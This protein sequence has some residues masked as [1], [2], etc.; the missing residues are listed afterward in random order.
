MF[1]S[2]ETTLDKPQEN[3]IERL[4]QKTRI[5]VML[6]ARFFQKGEGN[7]FPPRFPLVLESKKQGM[8]K[9]V[10]GGDVRM[11]AIEQLYEEFQSS[12]ENQDTRLR[13]FTTG[14]T[15]EIDIPETGETLK[16]SRAKQAENKL[17]V[18]Y[19][20]PRDI[21][22]TLPSGGSTI[23]NAKA[24]AEWLENNKEEV[25]QIDEIEIITNEF[26]IS[27]AWLMFAMALYKNETGQDLTLTEDERREIH[28]VLDET[29]LD[30]EFGDKR[31]LATVQAILGSYVGG[32]TLRVKPLIAEDILA[33]RGPSGIK[34][35]ELIRDNEYV[36]ETRGFE[37]QG[38]KDLIDGKYQVK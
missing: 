15:E 10:V 22:E 7:E 8:P 28:T 32:L 30:E 16:I 34:Y 24:L 35:G 3:K 31:E 26:H 19:G 6:G 9:E 29:L 14:G 5:I 36:Q 1:E 11:R 21:V 18:K 33:R 2:L 25:G 23:G 20:L 4:R 17:E 27:R 38:I 12:E 37:R 13:I